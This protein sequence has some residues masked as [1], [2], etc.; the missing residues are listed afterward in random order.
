MVRMGCWLPGHVP[1]VPEVPEVLEVHVV[2]RVGEVS[3]VQPALEARYPSRVPR[4]ENA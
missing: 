1:E 3:R 4:G 2:N